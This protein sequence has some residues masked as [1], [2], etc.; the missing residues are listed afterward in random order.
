MPSFLRCILLGPSEGFHEYLID[1]SDV[2]SLFALLCEVA[3]FANNWLSHLHSVSEWCAC[4]ANYIKLLLSTHM[5]LQKDLEIREK[6]NT[7]KF[8]FLVLV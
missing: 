4:K 6:I 2:L 8:G 1:M 3:V 7:Y 5:F